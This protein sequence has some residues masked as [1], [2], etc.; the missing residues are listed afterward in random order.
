[1]D[2]LNRFRKLWV[3]LGV[4]A[5]V[6][7]LAAPVAGDNGI[8]PDPPPNFPEIDDSYPHGDLLSPLGGQTH[9]HL[10]VLYV[11]FDDLPFEMADVP[12][13]PRFDHLDHMTP[14]A[15][16]EQ[17]FGEFPSVRDYFE[18]VSDGRLIL[19]PVPVTEDANEDGV[20]GVVQISTNE[21]RDPHWVGSPAQEMELLLEEA[22]EYIDFSQFANEDGVITELELSVVRHDTDD[23]L[24]CQPVL[25]DG[26][27][28][29]SD[30]V[31]GGGLI[32]RGPSTSFEVD[33][34]SFRNA[35]SGAY[36]FVLTRTASNLMTIVHELGHQLFDMPDSYFQNVG[37]RSDIGGGTVNAF[38]ND[39]FRPNA[40]H[41]MHLGWA[42]P[43]VVTTSGYYD[44]PRDPAGSSFILYDPERGIDDYFIV[45]NR[46]SIAG[47]YDQGVGSTGLM[48]W[49][50]DESEYVVVG[51]TGW[52][53]LIGGSAR[54]P[55]DRHDDPRRTVDGLEWRDG[56]PTDLAIRA[57]SPA[58]DDMRVYFDVRGPGV[59]VD[60]ILR[61]SFG[62]VVFPEVTP[63]VAKEIQVPVMNTGEETDTFSVYF[64]G[65]AGW[66][67]VPYEI[68]L[69]AGE[70]AD[71]FPA[72]IPAADTPVDAFELTVIAESTTDASV[73]ERA[74]LPVVV[75]L[76]RTS[77]EYTG[78]T[79]VPIDEPAGFEVVVTN[80]D[81]GDAPIEGIEVTFELSGPGG[82]LTETGITDFYGIAEANPIIALPPGDYVVVASTERLGRHD[83][84]STSVA[85]RIP[86][87]EER[88]GDLLDDIIAAE[89]HHGIEN[90]LS[91]TVGQ[92]LTSL[93]DDMADVTCNTLDA[94]RNQ[95]DAQEGKHL[96]A[97][98]AEGFRHDVDGIRSQIGC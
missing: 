42:E 68:E 49:R 32:D 75:V 56:T 30:E 84:A 6:L 31:A 12:P 81:D 47:T 93:E 21:D 7:M 67:T 82:E 95:L 80:I 8:Y 76:D 44:V 94:F 3:I 29:N 55:S 98:V 96:P 53:E 4:M 64:D 70:Q 88:I 85:Y 5:I 71:A 86:T 35:S 57:I 66:D 89:L 18:E 2:F 52:I 40:W 37:T 43:T 1:M 92:A 62:A 77:I 11:E 59:L 63:G 61:N 90:S 38:Y 54:N 9:R 65:P 14:W 16:H 22:S 36:R 41:Y 26:L 19:D 78:Q 73:S 33:D 87:V 74:T 58:G 34:V 60:P 25:P 28:C 91:A 46:A 45:E 17:F 15:V 79:Y 13:D 51:T 48:V 83:G 39:L 27:T 50:V 97:D 20:D 69:D 24:I 23:R 10:L 72:I